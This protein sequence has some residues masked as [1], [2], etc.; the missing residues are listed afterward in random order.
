MLIEQTAPTVA[1]TSGG[2]NG[3]VRGENASL[4]TV[5]PAS[6]T[7]PVAEAIPI[8]VVGGLVL[9]GD[10]VLPSPGSV[11]SS[12]VRAESVASTV[13]TSSDAGAEAPFRRRVREPSSFK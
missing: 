13:R 12:S 8:G 3:G 5:A 1:A 9:R 2:P 6:D 4:E 7:L 10:G 11:A